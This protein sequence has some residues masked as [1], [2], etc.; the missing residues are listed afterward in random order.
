[1]N[2]LVMLACLTINYL[3]LKDF[4]RFDDGWFFK[5]RCKVENR[6]QSGESAS[7]AWVLNLLVIFLFPLTVL[8]AALLVLA[9]VAF[10]IPL[11]V[12][13]GLVVLVALDR[14]QP[15]KLAAEFI[16]KWQEGG[17]TPAKEYLAL[18][19]DSVELN[20]V[21][22]NRGLADFFSK[23]L[24]HRSF[25][26]MFVA[27]FWYMLAGPLSVAFSYICYQ[28]KDSHDESQA[29][30]MVQTVDSFISVLEWVPVRL[31]GLTFSLAGNFVQCFESVKR[32]FWDFSL[33]S[34]NAE[35]LYDYSKC[36][37]SGIVADF[38]EE[39]E[40]EADVHSPIAT[41][42]IRIKALRALLDRSQAIWLVILGL[43][44]IF[45]L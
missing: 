38:A 13:H 41:E 28:L 31:L 8:L 4:D 45:G 14:K 17:M 40:V 11:M 29:T 16:A 20:D 9:D 43:I 2:F 26:R 23:Q 33:A 5:F 27:F 25:E 22:D 7:S 21:K 24:I 35:H 19:F 37:L 6:A 39:D 34:D 18:E 1:M 15:G 10:G 12:L 3:W 32:D 30:A 42:V 44:T 36:A